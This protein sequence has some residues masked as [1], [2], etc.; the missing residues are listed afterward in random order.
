MEVK[1]VEMSYVN[2]GGDVSLEG[3]LQESSIIVFP[4]FDAPYKVD[5]E[6]GEGGHGGGDPVLLR[7]IFAEPE[8]DIYNRAASH[9]DGALSILTGIAGNKSLRT[10]MPVRVDDLVQF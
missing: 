5:L 10:G 8:N 4:M 7:D 6:Q 1:I 9:V 2:S 3:A